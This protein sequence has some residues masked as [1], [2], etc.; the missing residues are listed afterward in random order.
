MRIPTSIRPLKPPFS[1]GVTPWNGRGGIW[2]TII[3]RYEVFIQTGERFHLPL[4]EYE[5]GWRQAKECRSGS[6]LLEALNEILGVEEVVTGRTQ[7]EA[8]LGGSYTECLETL[9]S[10]TLHLNET[11]EALVHAT[12]G[13]LNASMEIPVSRLEEEVPLGDCSGHGNSAPIY[14]LKDFLITCIPLADYDEIE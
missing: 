6:Y 10:E 8:R 1:L 11:A 12:I 13:A 9:T 7:F 2:I 14:G 3:V 5:L 4:S